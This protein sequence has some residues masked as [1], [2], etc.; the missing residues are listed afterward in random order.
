MSRALILDHLAVDDLNRLGNV[1]RIGGHLAH[2][3]LFHAVELL[4]AP[5]DD[6]AVTLGLFCGC[7]RFVCLRGHR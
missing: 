1:E 6:N 7:G 3:G 2:I 5:I 4:G